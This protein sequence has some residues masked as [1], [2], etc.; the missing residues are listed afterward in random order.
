MSFSRDFGEQLT[1]LSE[2]NARMNKLCE[3]L[4]RDPG[5]LRRSVN[6]FDAEARAAGGRLRYYDDES[7]LVEL[8]S[9]LR[10]AGFT[11]FGLYYPADPGQLEAFEHAA[12]VVVPQFR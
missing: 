4:G 3:E 12:Q 1:E 10:E 11:E 7:L 5:D 9:S 6:L 2:R 8:I